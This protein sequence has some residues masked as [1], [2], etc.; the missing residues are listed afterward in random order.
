MIDFAIIIDIFKHKNIHHGV[1][2]NLHPEMAISTR[3]LFDKINLRFSSKNK[4]NSSIIIPH[5]YQKIG[6]ILNTSCNDWKNVFNSLDMANVFK[7]PFIWVVV[8]EDLKE[9]TK[10]L[11]KYPIEIDSDIT[12]IYKKDDNISMYEIFNTGFALNGKVF[13]RA[14]GFWNKT[15]HIEKRSRLDLKGLVLKSTIVISK[16]NK[17][18]HKTFSDFLEHHQPSLLTVDPMHKFKYFAVLKYYRDMFNIR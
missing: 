9:T 3:A 12:I 1:A 17:I 15:L 13:V 6:I 16:N 7:S 2:L 4:E 10:V 8:T 5:F 18:V 14:I 11:S